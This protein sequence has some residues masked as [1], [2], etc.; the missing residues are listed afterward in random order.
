MTRNA[1]HPQQ[2]TPRLR[3]AFTALVTPFTADGA[4]D[5]TAY[6]R[7]VAW[8]VDGR[9]RRPRPGRHHR[10]V[11]DADAAGARPPASRSPST[12]VAERSPGTRVPRHRRYGLQRHP[13]LDRGHAAGRRPGRRRRAHR[14]AL[15]Q[16]ARPADARRPLPRDRGRGRP[17][18]RRLQRARTD[19]RQR[20]GGHVPAPRRAP[21]RDRGQGGERQHRADRGDLPGPAAGRGRA[22][23]RRRG[24][25]R[26]PGDGRRRRDLRGQQ[27]DPGRDVRALPRRTRGRLRAPRAGSTTAGCRCCA[28]TS[29]VHRTR[30]R[31]RP[32]CWRW[33]SWS[34][35]TFAPRSCR[36]PTA[37]RERLVGLLRGLGLVGGGGAPAIGR[38]SAAGGRH[39]RRGARRD[40]DRLTAALDPR[41]PRRRP[42]PCRRAGPVGPRRLAGGPGGQGRDP[43]LLPG[44]RRPSRGTSATSSASGTVSACRQGAPRRRRPTRL[45]AGRPWRIV[46]GGTSVR[47]GVYLAP[48]VVVMP[49]S[50]VNVGAWIGEDTMVDS[51]V[52]VGSCAQIGARVHLS[53]GVSI[54]GVL[55]PAGA[56]PVIVEDGAFVG[57]GSLAARGRAGG[58]AARSSG[59]A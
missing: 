27:P 30:C 52:L 59:R 29:R 47:A 33:A 1:R 38:R 16:Q 7:L 17:A 55:E 42:P 44:P 48:G 53:A 35:T 34:A 13:R 10:R 43:R 58:R 45:A 12:A 6:R 32:R 4:L 51:H 20:G 54:G 28:R 23:R 14:H 2:P 41:R 22:L 21:A 50:F 5:E 15:L 11:A 18:D 3:G 40:D 8:Q 36:W 31:R 24:D 19:R 37:P 25:A 57:A 26:G 49:P 9:H 46:P 39:D 56:R